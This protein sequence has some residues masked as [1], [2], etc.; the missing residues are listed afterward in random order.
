MAAPETH[1]FITINASRLASGQDWIT[2]G[3][4]KTFGNKTT[5]IVPRLKGENI[6]LVAVA[7]RNRYMWVEFNADESE[8][9]SGF[10]L[11]LESRQTGKNEVAISIISQTFKYPPFVA[12]ARHVTLPGYLQYTRLTGISQDVD[13]QYV[14][15]A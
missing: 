6:A 12:S 3:W 1:V 5:Q 2:F 8:T 9:R 4:G 11:H 14:T 10:S 13:F 15:M 7:S